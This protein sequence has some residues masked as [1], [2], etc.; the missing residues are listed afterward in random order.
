MIW[1]LLQAI[2]DTSVP[3]PSEPEHLEQVLNDITYFH[4]APQVYQ[5]LKQQEKLGCLP[6]AFRD[7]LK[8]KYDETVRTNLYIQYENERILRAFEASGIPVIPLKGVYFAKKYFG[9]IGARATSDIDLLLEES[10]MKRAEACIR[11]LGFTCEE[12]QIR[13]HF[14]RSYSKPITGTLHSLAIELHW[15]LLMRG[16]SRLDIAPF[17]QE[18]VP[19][20]PYKQVM[21]LSDYH[22]FYMICLHGWKHGLNS[23]KYLLDIVQ[24]LE[25][26][27]DRICFDRLLR[28]ASIHRTNKRIA[29]T[30]SIVY[31]Q[32]PYLEESKPL[33]LPKRRGNWWYYDAIRGN[34][35]NAFQR[36]SR[37]LQYQW[38]DFDLPSHSLAASIHYLE[39]LVMFRKGVRT[40]D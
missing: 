33:H 21:E 23:P 22:Q 37:F 25:V 20:K 39:S 40:S 4:I 3:I 38:L 17:W 1:K 35:K 26:S 24:L 2:Y 11:E 19:L 36:Y 10:D 31:R 16:T 5:L 27:G 18:A 29:S 15:G 6:S 12:Q 34:K 14:H 28:E 7:R 9:H 32:F 13:A 30:L 8:L